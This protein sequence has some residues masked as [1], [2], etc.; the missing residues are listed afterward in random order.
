MRSALSR[1]SRM[2]AAETP[3]VR[4]P[5]RAS[6]WNNATT[7]SAFPYGSSR[8][9]TVRTALKI[10]VVA[11]IPIPRVKMVIAVK[12]GRRRSVLAA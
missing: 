6:V 2:L 12:P 9:S 10:A 3:S 1:T 4:A 7:R 8:S 11:P 5:D